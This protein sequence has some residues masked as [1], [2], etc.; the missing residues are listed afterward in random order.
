VKTIVSEIVLQENRLRSDRRDT[1]C[2]NGGKAAAAVTLSAAIVDIQVENGNVTDGANI[3][4]EVV[5]KLSIEIRLNESRI[6]PSSGSARAAFFR[7]RPS[8]SVP[9]PRRHLQSLGGLI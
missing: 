5:L 7:G 8:D 4:T 6:P 3:P 9:S 1:G 2:Q